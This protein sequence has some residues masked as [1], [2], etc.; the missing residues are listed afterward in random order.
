MDKLQ[1]IQKIFA[2]PT[3]QQTE[4]EL[5]RLV[6]IRVVP[7]KKG[8][9]T[10]MVLGCVQNL[11]GDLI[12]LVGYSNNCSNFRDFASLPKDKAFR[13]DNCMRTP[14]RIVLQGSS[15]ISSAEGNPAETTAAFPSPEITGL[16]EVALNSSSGPWF[17]ETVTFTD[18]R[19]VGRCPCFVCCKLC[20]TKKLEEEANCLRCGYQDFKLAFLGI[21]HLTN[22]TNATLKAFVG[23]N[24][25]LQLIGMNE[26]KFIDRVEEDPSM[27]FVHDQLPLFP[28]LH[29][30]L[31]RSLN[32]G[33]PNE[34]LYNLERLVEAGESMEPSEK[35]L[36]SWKKRQV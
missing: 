19:P 7:L 6:F 4:S 17:T 25:L 11:A 34:S 16:G 26:E 20:N 9:G 31:T 21:A 27:G 12:Q 22:S 3:E 30:V 23:L 32:K 18:L 10:L 24:E 13:L 1:R 33:N 28:K 15:K 8:A 35:R 29:A 36:R 2:S 14:T 5:Y